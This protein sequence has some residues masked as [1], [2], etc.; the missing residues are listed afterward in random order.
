MPSSSTP[1]SIS[2]SIA[3]T[4]PT[5]LRLSGTISG[6]GTLNKWKN[7]STLILSGNNTYSGGTII[8]AGKIVCESE[9]SLGSGSLS[10][11][12]GA[13]LQLDFVGSSDV[14]S[15]SLG[16]S[17]AAN[18]TWG[19]SASP[20]DN[21]NDTYFSGLGI[22]TVG[23][24][25]TPTTTAIALTGGANPTDIGQSV[26][27]T[28]TVSGGSPT[29][30]VAF[31][32]GLT[33][34]GSSA[35]NGSFQASVS[36]T[37]LPEGTRNIVAQYQGDATYASSTS[38]PLPVQVVDARPATTTTLALTS[39]SQPVAFRRIRDLHGDGRGFLAHRHGR[40]L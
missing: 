32:D 22:V 31:Y 3:P 28:A 36:T 12:S 6:G 35:I 8:A 17:P 34:L 39:G 9:T 27:F 1:A 26:T 30:T 14:T 20:A 25:K 38:A 7:A 40:I 5:S 37:A 21:R 19:S 16:G 15:L 23:P 10:I 33:Q 11:A 29:G 18:G 4:P 2:T 13:K 24:P